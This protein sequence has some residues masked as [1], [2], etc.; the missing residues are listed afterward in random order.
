MG[1]REEDEI[2]FNPLLK[3]NIKRGIDMN[4]EAR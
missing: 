3:L 4:R 1:Y 2:N